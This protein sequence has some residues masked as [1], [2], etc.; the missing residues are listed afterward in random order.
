VRSGGGWLP[1]RRRHH[2]AGVRH[3]QAGAARIAAFERI[4]GRIARS[5]AQS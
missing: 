4:V 2:H 5:V 3:R 1:R